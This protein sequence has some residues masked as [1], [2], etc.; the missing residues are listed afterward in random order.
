MAMGNII[1]VLCHEKIV[2]DT[3]WLTGS[4]IG[5]PYAIGTH[6]CPTS[7]VIHM[8]IT[9]IDLRLLRVFLAVVDSRGFSNAQAILGRDASTI[10]RQIT[11][12]ECRLGFKLCERGRSGFALTDEGAVI[13]RRAVE[14]FAVTRRFEHDAIAMQR[15]LS[16]PIRIA[17]IDNLITDDNCPLTATIQRFVQR[18]HNQAEFFIDIA[19]PARIEQ[20]VLDNRSDIGIGIFSHNLQELEYLPLYLEQDLL[21]AA[22]THPLA[23]LRGAQL[24]EALSSAK[25]VVREFLD[26]A[27]LLPLGAERVPPNAWV[28]NIEAAAML[29]LAGNHIGFLPAH[30]AKRWVEKGE[31]VILD[32]AQYRRSSP[33]QAITRKSKH[34]PRP[35]LK[36]FIDDLLLVSQTCG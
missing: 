29:I 13:Y 14:L 9:D 17:M 8:N 26:S 22:V 20:A 27:D 28:S 3:V 10:S 12:L 35:V 23:A 15:Q 5:V 33:I 32:P 4:E 34:A 7:P 24:Q 30:F 1:D 6:F 16:G 21:Y 2:S 18:E 36:A 25:K 19:A 31:L 11:Q